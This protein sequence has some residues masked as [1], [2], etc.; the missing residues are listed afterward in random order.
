MVTS[1]VVPKPTPRQNR[2]PLSELPPAA[3]H[4][5]QKG[6]PTLRPERRGGGVHLCTPVS[7]HRG[8]PVDLTFWDDKESTSP[9]RP[10]TTGVKGAHHRQARRHAGAA[11]TAGASPGKPRDRRC[12]QAPD[13]PAAPGCWPAPPPGRR[14]GPAPSALCLPPGRRAHLLRYSQKQCWVHSLTGLPCGFPS[15][16]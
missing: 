9:Q 7:L 2:R 14:G 11:A 8:R 1:A 16:A 5:L 6:S 3:G 10:S 12:A 15:R 4:N 13:L